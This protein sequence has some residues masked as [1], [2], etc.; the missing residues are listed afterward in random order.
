[1]N[2]MFY[3]DAYTKAY[4]RLP[5]E[6]ISMIDGNESIDNLFRDS[7]FRGVHYRTNIACWWLPQAGNHIFITNKIVPVHTKNNWASKNGC[8]LVCET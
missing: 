2:L 5:R 4:L 3:Q 8:I 7:F 1:M 6:V